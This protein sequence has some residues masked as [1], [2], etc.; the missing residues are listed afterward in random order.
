MH[1]ISASLSG[2]KMGHDGLL[3][4]LASLGRPTFCFLSQWRDL[5]YSQKCPG[6]HGDY[7]V[8]ADEGFTT[9]C[10]LC[11]SFFPTSPSDAHFVE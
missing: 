10:P 2:W 5:F 6:L 11:V 7:V 9:Q 1:L 3:H 8:T 4:I